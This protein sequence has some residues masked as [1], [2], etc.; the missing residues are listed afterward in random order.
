VSFITK[1]QSLAATKRKYL[2]EWKLL[3]QII[4]T[5]ILL[6][7]LEAIF[8]FY[9]NDQIVS[10]EFL[11][12]IYL[13][14]S[15]VLIAGAVWHLKSYGTDLESPHLGM[16][17]GMTLGMQTGMMVGMILG[18]TDGF[19]VGALIAMV[20][21]VALGALGGTCSGV[22]GIL[23]GLMAGSMGGIMGAMAGTMLLDDLLWFMPPFMILNFIIMFGLVYMVYKEVTEKK[24]IL[25]KSPPRFS[26]FFLFNV[27]ALTLLT[28]AVNLA[29]ESNMGNHSGMLH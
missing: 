9:R 12:D 3:N 13:T 10:E 21:A 1:T 14:L 28:L 6:V 16:M 8:L 29:P 20:V 15:V 27:V 17:T 4:V 24:G 26:Q 5:F 23:E 22:A 25:H 18:A 2:F 11:L 19:F 7:S